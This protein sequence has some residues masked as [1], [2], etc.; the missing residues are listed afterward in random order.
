MDNVFVMKLGWGIL[1]DKCSL[2]ARFLRAKYVESLVQDQQLHS[3]SSYSPIWKA[4]CNVLPQVVAGTSWSTGNGKK[5]RFWKDAWLEGF[6]Q[7]LQ[8]M[9]HKNLP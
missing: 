4:V 6:S 5:I 7:L 9:W 3:R 1:N 8:H 2:W